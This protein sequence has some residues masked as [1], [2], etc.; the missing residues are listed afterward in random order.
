MASSE[1]NLQGIIR[2]SSTI[3]PCFSTGFSMEDNF[4]DFLFAIMKKK[5]MGTTH[6]GK[7]LLQEE[8]IL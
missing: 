3:S 6:K 7:N 5:Q 4:S 1:T 2:K 8:K